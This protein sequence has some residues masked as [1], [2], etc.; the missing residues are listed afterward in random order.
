VP[1]KVERWDLQTLDLVGLLLHEQPVGY[2]SVNLPRMDELRDAPTRPPDDFEATGLEGL[3]RGEDLFVRES[4]DCRRVLGAVRSTRQCLS[5][6]GGERGDL[7]RAFSY[8]F[9][10]RKQ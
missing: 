10:P 6:H 1:G 8:T 3:R 4:A 9:T 2:V 7:L 5:C